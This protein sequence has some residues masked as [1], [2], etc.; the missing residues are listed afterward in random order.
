MKRL[1]I[2]NQLFHTQIQDKEELLAV[3]HNA[4]EKSIID[5]DVLNI[6]E[7]AIQI[8][9]LRAK[10]IM[11]PRNQ[12]DVLDINDDVTVLIDKVLTTGHSRFPVIDGFI[13]KILGVFH[14][15][16]L[17]RYIV[18]PQEF[19]L[20]SYLREAYFVPEI[21]YLDSL[22]YE[23]RVKQIHLAIVV[24]E[25]TNVVGIVSLEMIVEQLIGDIEDEHDSVEAERDILEVDINTYRIK[26]RCKLAEINDM[27][28]LSWHDEQVETVGGFLT[29]VLGR[30][31]YVGE[32]LNFAEVSIE[33]INADSRKIKLLNIKKLDTLGMA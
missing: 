9:K 14:S 19:D 31:P 24:D 10:D 22:M 32:I 21:K 29:K 2:L 8:T 18:N 5:S 33:V 1:K 11:L 30:I 28:G 20:R 23:M 26:G 27:L 7:S 6:I 3:L 15:K 16:D 25:F 12:V 4:T 13:S 17:I